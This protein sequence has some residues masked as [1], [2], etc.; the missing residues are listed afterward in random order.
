MENTIDNRHAN[1]ALIAE[2]NTLI[3]L[4]EEHLQY[5]FVVENDNFGA[6][7]K[8]KKILDNVRLRRELTGQTKYKH[9][10]M[11]VYVT[12]SPPEEEEHL[13]Q[14]RTEKCANKKW[15][16]H[17]LYAFEQRSKD[18]LHPHG[19][20]THLLFYRGKKTPSS[21]KTEI[22]RTF[23]EWNLKYQFTNIPENIVPYLQGF[24]Q[25]EL[26]PTHSADLIWRTKR[27]LANLYQCHRYDTD[28]PFSLI[29]EE[30]DKK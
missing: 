5:T 4:Y 3:K 23:P 17:Y 30:N 21:I 22:G 9:S 12:I 1:A 18:P 20:H 19:A 14:Q 16:E 7:G 27:G 6:T 26:K 10:P 25:G 28:C 11:Y 15:M 13:L 2:R 29:L 8:F 24:K